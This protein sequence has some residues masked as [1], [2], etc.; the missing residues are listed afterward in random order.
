MA[1]KFR[2][3][4]DYYIPGTAVLKNKLNLT[5]ANELR[6]SEEKL[7]LYRLTEL[8]ANPIPG[9]FD[10]D[11]MKQIH[12]HIFQDVYEW[13]GQERVGPLG[14]MTKAGP[15]VVNFAPGDPAAPTVAYGY[16]PAPAISAA[17]SDQYG[18]L[19]RDKYLTGLDKQH[20]VGELAEYWGEINTIHA[21][22]EGNTRA[23]FVFFSQ[24]ADHAGYRLDPEAFKNS[25]PLRDEFVAARFYNQATT[26]IDR[27]AEI[28][29][30]VTAPVNNTERKASSSAELVE[31]ARRFPELYSDSAAPQ[32]QHSGHTFEL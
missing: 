4:D 20:F 1:A 6:D 17:A 18:K 11:H 19:S 3:W 27:L 21:F 7:A 10:Y 13:A 8:A 16:Y 24:L 12:R 31:R 23:Q 9:A 5:S 30:K 15:D 28:L 25:S 2:A 32:P 22:R 26:R 14:K 29:S